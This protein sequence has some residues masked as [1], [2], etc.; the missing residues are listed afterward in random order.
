MSVI[1]QLLAFGLSNG[2]IIALNALGVTLVYSV[3]RQVNF[4]YGDLFALSSVVV[5]SAVAALGIN[6]TSGASMTVGGLLLALAAAMAFGALLNVV[7]EQ[8]VFRPFVGRSRLA[9][10]VAGI[11]VSLILFQ[12]AVLWRTIAEVGIGNAEHHSD[13]DNLDNVSHTAIPDLLPKGNLAAGLPF[14]LIYTVKDLLVLGTAL[15][16]TA[17]T[18]YFLYRTRTGNVLRACAQDAEMAALCGVNQRAMVRLV[19]AIGG[20]LAG[21]A[22]FVF[23]LYY[24]R[25]YGFHGAESGLTAFAAAV[26]GGVG[27]PFGALLGGLLLG[28]FGSFSDYFL[29]ARWTPVLTLALLIGLLV[30]RPTGIGGEASGEASNG[31]ALARPLTA[32]RS[33]RAMWLALGLALLYPPLDALLGLRAVPI[34]NN[35]IIFTIL[36]LGL[37]VVLGFAGLLDLGFAACFAV[38]GYTAALLMSAAGGRPIDFTLLLLAAMGSAGLFGLLNGVLTLRLRG[39]YLAIVALAFGQMVP[40]I[41]V[42]LSAQTGGVGGMAALPAPH[43]LGFDF[44]THPQR[45]YLALAVLALLLLGALRLQRSRVGRAWAALR[46]DELAALSCGVNIRRYKPL[47]FTVGASIAGAAALLSATIFSYVDPDQSDFRVSALTL[48]MVVIGGAGSV[49]GALLG[50][51][52]VVGYD[53]LL[54]PLLGTAGDAAIFK[55]TGSE[56][57][58]SVRTLSG[59]AFGLALYLTVLL[60]ARRRAA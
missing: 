6:R 42:N 37:N 12:G 49:P 33:Q 28:T 45:F 55:L 31:D 27:N 36:A 40:R 7:I 60:R 53:Q 29:P 44:A 21:A 59:F 10:L 56:P 4:A 2:A 13:I 58:L 43:L 41:I 47:A 15:L 50:A 39:D 17:G 48:A 16:L 54:F 18:A 11:G 20:A 35:S 9:P 26:L 5:T 52:L 3:V 25:P 23:A 19:F 24:G 22:A 1:L 46:E 34:V 51:L 38:G 30:L 32:R 57:L 14:P 8:I